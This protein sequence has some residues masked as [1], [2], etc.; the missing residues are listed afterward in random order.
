[1]FLA[2]NLKPLT[3]KDSYPSHTYRHPHPRHHLEMQF[4][5]P[6]EVAQEQNELLRPIIF[7]ITLFSKME[8]GLL[9]IH[10]FS[11]YHS[12]TKQAL[13]LSDVF[14]QV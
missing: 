5:S 3:C 12:A 14:F 4:Y 2:F 7:V 6:L 13:Y 8:K 11:V 10:S 1:M 9:I